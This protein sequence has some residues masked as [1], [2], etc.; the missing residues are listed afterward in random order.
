MKTKEVLKKIKAI[1]RLSGMFKI[2]NKNCK[3]MSINNY[4]YI[5]KNFKDVK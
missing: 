5:L 1:D 4:K 2:N 3:I